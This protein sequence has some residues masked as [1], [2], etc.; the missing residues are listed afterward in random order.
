[1]FRVEAVVAGAGET[2]RFL[3]GCTLGI[4]P[5]WFAGRDGDR[6]AASCAGAVRLGSVVQVGIEPHVAAFTY[7]STP[8][9]ET[10]A[11]LGDA[12]IAIAFEPMGSLGLRTGDFLVQ[13]AGGAGLGDAPGTAAARGMLSVTY[14]S[15]AKPPARATDEPDRD[16][17]GISDRYDA[18]PDEAGTEE[19]RGCPEQRDQDGDGIMEGD[20]CPN[21]PGARY[22]D[23]K[24]NG[25]ADRDNDHIAD[26]VDECQA[27]PGAA[28]GGCPRHARLKDK[29]FVVTPTLAFGQ[30]SDRLQATQVASLVEIVRTIRAN[31]GLGHFAVK[32]GSK[33]AANKLTDARAAAVLAILNEQNL[34]S[35]RYELVLDDKLTNGA[36]QVSLTR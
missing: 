10:M 30:G 15:Q 17:D 32:L 6:L 36:L 14:A 21:E 1:L 31:P 20:A 4:A 33:G 16:V 13:L 12:R 28:P 34:E 7:R 25:C 18:C 3:Y 22:E 29:Q 8:D 23:P 27:E 26:P 35:N 5:M 11:G 24:A 2:E 19:R 9:Q